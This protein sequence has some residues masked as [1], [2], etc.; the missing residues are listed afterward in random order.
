METLTSYVLSILL[1]LIDRIPSIFLMI[2]TNVFIILSITLMF[3][4]LGVFLLACIWLYLWMAS[5]L[6]RY[7]IVLFKAIR[8]IR[9]PWHNNSHHQEIPT[10]AIL[11]EIAPPPLEPK[12]APV[13]KP[14][15]K[16]PSVKR[17][18][19][20]TSSSVE[21]KDIKT[22]VKTEIEATYDTTAAAPLQTR[23]RLRKHVSL[24]TT[25]RESITPPNTPESND[26][27][28]SLDL[29]PFPSGIVSARPPR[30]P[31]LKRES[32]SLLDPSVS[33]KYFLPYTENLRSPKRARFS[34]TSPSSSEISRIP[35]TPSRRRGLRPRILSPLQEAFSPPSRDNTTFP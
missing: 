17:R 32:L 28:R 35:S 33:S 22:E 9:F 4:A 34:L 10:E 2:L 23:S 26:S 27:E 19:R 14:P 18:M 11:P 31:P 30:L 20:S 29:R 5:Y 6:S 8:Q 3:L 16:F 24:T 15:P 21:P 13:V 25:E 7:A 12:V 1:R